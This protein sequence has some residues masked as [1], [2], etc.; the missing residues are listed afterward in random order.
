MKKLFFLFLFTS[1]NICL[2]QNQESYFKTIP[3]DLSDAPDWAKLMYSDDPNIREVAFKYDQYYQQNSFIKS[4]HTQNFKHWIRNVEVHQDSN[5]KIRPESSEVFHDK[6]NTITRQRFGSNY[7]KSNNQWTPIGPFHTYNESEQGNFPV[8]WQGNIYSFD[9]SQSDPN[10]LFAGSEAG[11]VFKSIDKGLN[12]EFTSARIPVATIWD[13]K[14]SPSN[15]NIVYIISNQRVYKSEDQ[16]NTWVDVYNLQSVAYQIEIHQDDPNIIFVAG[17]SGLFVSKD[18]GL[19]WN[20]SLIQKTW[21]IKFNPANPNILYI[22]QSNV[23]GNHCQ[24]L[25]STDMGESWNFK[26]SGWYVPTDPSNAVDQGARIAVTKAN[27]EYVYV[28]LLGESKANDVGW[29]GLYKSTD[30]GET[31]N[32]PNLPDGGPYNDSSHQNLATI[33]R[34]GT[35]FHQGFYNFSIAASHMD[36]ERLWIG[37]LA[38]S[39]SNNGGESW[40]RIGSYNAANDIGWI[41]PDIQDL[42][43]LD[44]DVWVCSD[45]GINYSSDELQTHESRVNGLFASDYWGFGQGWNQ[46]VM[47]GGRYH[48]GNSGYYETYG[49][50]NTL[51]LGGAEAATGYV[52]PLKERKA[53]FSDISTKIIPSQI[54]GPTTAL[55]QLGLYPNET[56]SNSYSSELVFDP[57]YADHFYIGKDDKIWKSINEGAQFF[58]LYQFEQSGRVL[59]IEQSRS[60]P[61]V[62]YCVYQIGSSYWDDCHIYKSN[63][64]GI[65]WNKCTDVPTNDT[66]RLEISINP[67]DENELWVIAINGFSSQLV[68]STTDGAIT[69]ENKTTPILQGHTPSDIKYQ[70]GT[71]QLVYLTSDL[72][73]FYWNKDEQDWIDCSEGLPLYTRAMEIEPFYRDSKLRMATWGR[74]I[75]ESSFISKSKPIAQP[76]TTTDIVYCS[77]DT[78]Q[79]DC[80][81]I[82]N[83]EGASWEWSFTP[84]PIYISDRNARNPKVLLGDSGSFDV[85]LKI[86]D[87]SGQSST[88]TETNMVTVDNRCAVDTF[89]GAVL[90]CN[91]SGDYAATSNLGLYTNEMTFSA[92]IKPDGNQAEYTGIIMN[93]GEAGG[94]NFRPN[95]ELGYHWPGGA[96]WWSSGLIVPANE[97]SY[98][99][100]VVK[101]NSVTVYLNGV[102]VTHNTQ[103]Q[104]IDVSS[105]LFGSYK[106]W[107]SRNFKGKIDEVCIWSR[108]LSQNEIREYR[109]LTKDDELHINDK[110]FIGYYQFNEINITR[111]LNKVGMAH[112]S[113]VGNAEIDLTPKVPVAKGTSERKLVNEAGIYVFDSSGIKIEL[114]ESGLYP[115]DELVATRLHSPPMP[116]YNSALGSNCYWIINNYGNEVY[117][118]IINFDLETVE[119]LN[120]SFTSNPNEGIL[121]NRGDNDEENTW[122]EVCNASDTN[123]NFIKFNDCTES[124][125]GQF[126]IISKNDQIPIV[127]DDILMANEVLQKEVVTVYPNPV[128]KDSKIYI[129]SGDHHNTRIKL[130]NAAGKLMLDQF[131]LNDNVDLPKNLNEGI[132]FYQLESKDYIKTGKLIVQ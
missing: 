121:L 75:Y 127:G 25:K 90:S 47:V 32:N 104:E 8:S 110:D 10:I 41:H 12:W 66:W 45:G 117:G 34:D 69:W 37:C 116:N 112:A 84:E 6:I 27:P 95:M 58:V 31:W 119:E 43:V 42:H 3:V 64:G 107:E 100:M 98:V 88:K 92:W 83:H 26:D 67:E 62:M 68:F 4:I 35:G 81:S 102:G 118:P 52:N 106:G 78:V 126:Y 13:V 71:D 51:R 130:F 85:S 16:G 38:L 19:T 89:P 40:T 22:V 97:W 124:A 128:I 105:L 55:N 21:D 46:D 132:Y 80:Y 49:I 114:A 77:R 103:T 113:L 59:E 70:A 54:D 79:F 63:D 123:D 39:E 120:T 18:G 44:N 74:G 125:S 111:V 93:N 11:G 23:Q 57:R 36:P 73:M 72:G 82:L 129:K 50:G 101:P 61:N 15:S 115:N 109:H 56:Y 65:S 14:I 91:L 122:L 7:K 86:T 60:N 30:S 76:M 2:A 24:L 9:Q 5:G 29:I 131:F 20:R 94:L 99:A 28:A 33:N 53:Y 108:A 87:G 48:N 1:V 17:E 96:W